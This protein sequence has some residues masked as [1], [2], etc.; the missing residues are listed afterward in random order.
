MLLRFGSKNTLD[1]A[2]FNTFSSRLETSS[3]N[4]HHCDAKLADDT[5]IFFFYKGE[6]NV[7][8]TIKPELEVFFDED[9]T[10]SF[11]GS[12]KKRHIECRNCNDIIGSV[13]SFG[14][15]S[16]DIKA[17]ACNRV[18]L[19]GKSYQGQRW[20][21]LYQTLPFESRDIQD[22]FKDPCQVNGM[23]TSPT[24]K[25]VVKEPV[26]FPSID[27]RKDFEWFTVS[28]TK[29][30]RD[31][32][33]QAFVEGLQKN[34]V[35]VLNT[36][37]GKTLIASM[38]LAKM[39]KLNP[40]RMGLMIVD[41][42]PL[43][44]Q[45]GDAIAEDTNLPVVSLCGENKTINII[46]K[47]N[48]GSY[49][50]LVVTAGA[51][52]EMLEKQSVDVSLFCAV[53]FDECHH[54]TGNHRYV[55]VM[56]KITSQILSHQPR[57]IGLTASPFTAST[58]KQGEINL[59]KFL[60]NFTD[61]K[62]YSP[63]LELSHQKTKKE[64]ISLSQDQQSFIKEVVARINEHIAEIVKA[65]DLQKFELKVDLS[66]TYQ[67]IGDLR[68]IE[69]HYPERKKNKDLRNALLL[70]EALEFAF[71]FGVPSACKFLKEEKV[72]DK[73]RKNFQYVT[74]L[75][76]RL[77][78]L[79]LYLKKANEGSRILVFVDRRSIARLLKRW[80]QKHFPDLNA[81]MVVGHGGYDGMAW[82]DQQQK[83]IR[84]FAKGESRLIVTTSVLEEGID[85]AQCDLVIAFTK[86]R[87]LIRFIQMRGRA[88]K[89]DSVFVIFE[90]EEERMSN[91][92]SENQEKVMRRVLAKHQ[93][94][95]FSVL[96][97]NIVEEIKNE[98]KS[99]E[100]AGDSST[101]VE[102]SLF[103]TSNN[104]L[105]FKLFMDPSEPINPTNMIEHI[106]IILKEIEFFKLKRFDVVSQ[107]GIFANSHVFS[108][109]ARM[110]IAY[111]SPISQSVT[112]SALYRRFVSFFDYRI[113]IADT[114]C[115][116]WS[117]TVVRESE[118]LTENQRVTSKKFSL[119]YFQNRSTVVVARTFEIESEIL[120]NCRKSIDIE[121]QA[122]D[123]EKIVINFSAMSK[124]I[125]L[126]VNKDDIVL[127]ITLS[128][129]PLFSIFDQG[130]GRWIRICGGEKP[131]YFSQHSLLML[132]FNIQD[133]LNLQK[134]F[135]SP[136]LFP[137]RILQTKLDLCN[138][139]SSSQIE[140]TIPWALKCIIDCREVCFP[141][142][143]LEKI[144]KELENKCN[145]QNPRGSRELC[146]SILSKLSQTNYRYF[147]DLNQQFIDTFNIAI[148]TPLVNKENKIVVKNVFH[149]KR[150]TVTP[151][152]IIS[153]PEILVASNRFLR[154]LQNQAEDVIIVTVRDDDTTKVQSDSFVDRFQKIF[155]NGIDICNKKYR[156]LLSTGSQIREHKGYFIRA[157]TLEEISAL[158]Q[159]FIPEPE[160][161]SSVAK[162]ICRL[163]MYGTTATYT[164]DLSM[165]SFI[166]ADDIK[167]ENGDLTTDGAGLISLSK[168]KELA[169]VLELDETPSAFQIR[170]SGFKGVVSCTYDDDPQLDGK[171][172]LMRKSMKKF[173]NGD[174]KF[175]VVQ[176]SKYRKLNLNREILNLLTSIK[177]YNIKNTLFRY[178]DKDL[179]E[180]VSM[181]ENDKIALKYLQS[182]L[183]QNDLKLI[184]NDI[185]KFTENKHWFEV[186]KGIYRLRTMNIKNRMNIIIE[187]GAL[188]MGVPDPYEVL[189]E[190]EVFVQLREEESSDPRIIQRR[191]FMYRNP[192]LHPG[193]HQIV[194]CVDSGKLHH[195]YNVVVIPAFH[196]KTSLAADCSGGDLDGDHFSVIWDENLV[197]PGNFEPLRYGELNKKDEQK[198]ER[199][200]EKENFQNPAAI[201]KFFTDFMINDELG[202]IAHKHLALCDIQDLGAR[203]ELAIEL[204]KC[205]VQAVHYSKT[206]IKP[207]MPK[208][209]IEIVS[210]SGFPDF[211]EKKFEESYQSV[212]NLGELYRHCKE[213]TF[214]FDPDLK[215]HRNFSD[216]LEF[217]KVRGFQKYIEDAE[218]VYE[219]YKYHVQMIIVK[220][221]LKTEV[222]V[223][224]AS[225]TYGWADE[226]EGNKEK[227]SEIIK[228][229]YAD[230]KK[231]CRNLFLNDKL[232]LADE[233]E[234]S[235]K[236]YAWYYVAYSKKP[237]DD[238]IKFLGFPWIVA[239]YL[240]QIRK[241]KDQNTSNKIN[242][243]IG[244]SVV[245]QF[246]QKY[247]KTLIKD[248]QAKFNYVQR[249]E[250]AINN[251]TKDKYQISRGFIVQPYG[252]TSLYVCEP[253]SDIDIC[254]V[255]T[256]ELS[257]T[258]VM[259]N[260]YFKILPEHKQQEYFL[261]LVVSRV[262]DSLACEKRD[263]FN[264]QTPFV[265][266]KSSNE[267]D[268]FSCDI[269]MNVN[270]LKKTYYFHHL[271]KKD[272][273]YF[274]VF[275]SLVKWARAA[276]LIRPFA[277]AEKG[278]IDTADFYALIAHTLNFPE[279]PPVDIT[280]PVNTINLS[281]L[282]NIILKCN[283][284]QKF[285]GI[286]PRVGEMI[287]LFFKEVSMKN[288]S[289]TIEWS[290]VHG[291]ED[292]K[293]VI[294]KPLVMSSISS[295]ASKAFHCLSVLRDSEG[296]LN[297]FMTSDECTEFTKNLST[298]LSFAIGKAKE[299]HSALL[300]ANTGAIVRIDTIDGL[301][302]YR[303]VAKGTRLQLDKLKKEIR[304]L[305]ESNRA[306]VLGR[307]PQ[308][309]SRYFMEGSS[310]LFSLQDTD[311]DSRVRFEPS[312]GA[313]QV[314]HRLRERESLILQD[315]DKE[316]KEGHEKEQYD[317][318]KAHIIE[319]MSS[320]PAKN[321][322]LLES[323]Q[324][325][326]RFGC[327]YFIEV[328]SNLPS[329]SKTVLFQELQI[330]LDKGR[331]K[332]SFWDREFV[333]REE[334]ES[335]TAAKGRS[336]Q[337]TE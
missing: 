276:E 110:F 72:L 22:F 289:I 244:K 134:I 128:Q 5:Q 100:R 183:P 133:Y 284:K 153:L 79:D 63:R 141:P 51:F 245:L 60:E 222:D 235:R 3:M 309:T 164:F 165:D 225:A 174:R 31:Y 223:I 151:T 311:Y 204:A 36:G 213:T 215:Q 300:G 306:L 21:N 336:Q 201:A 177:D 304:S 200:K 106:R 105:A 17:F 214:L 59:E 16:R 271:F 71:Y 138:S 129:V 23:A 238:K 208:K 315:V 299:F 179:E 234:K 62:I 180:L 269:S 66:N 34:I 291:L 281:T 287:L 27:K 41:R 302:N 142:D 266:F 247:Y 218:S 61:A 328:S 122:T 221:K 197:P 326:V 209:A 160:K 127:Y 229:W 1:F 205:Q 25:K 320:F 219:F 325:F 74:E 48:R 207:I 275:W 232:L 104:E 161:F 93:R 125:F 68:S 30:P 327:M 242:Y 2:G 85:V 297:Y 120:F 185:S 228:T 226:I 230:I 188:L 285:K 310:K 259:T 294:I 114:V 101:C 292:V 211:M 323:I 176:Y 35:V 11:S 305:M 8:L 307:L 54:L 216:Y 52:Y 6:R 231:T 81:Q 296:L 115:Q 12:G 70:I 186:L 168:A 146:E 92:K 40:G 169:G 32:Q 20:Y 107:K 64:L 91:R 108:S 53:I 172:F 264:S 46:N 196:C 318:F 149:I 265:K 278:V 126:T 111:V 198:N 10:L 243:I 261:D 136:S 49:D 178:M 236:A 268:R 154:E 314:L 98:C 272:W 263:I 56:K 113:T 190:N 249:V 329:E 288:E 187:D 193:D 253:E 312:Q 286:F 97:K 44:F 220:Y 337:K 158:R 321:T 75:S 241:R 206:G 224:L 13:L 194:Q 140:R 88:R 239:D 132:T 248:I 96:S 69:R 50:V 42:V 324:V 152:R 233:K 159:R 135:H 274:I 173:E 123:L 150:V 7:H 184:Y 58:E 119:G 295:Q 258:I 24:K 262:V 212:K 166:L 37:A 333:G 90:T 255:A 65:Y 94:C 332:R 118:D 15:G 280:E 29:S 148:D 316:W 254:A 330:A 227:I 76:G 124:F 18:K 192:C 82:E 240:C 83:C 4:C 102:L 38:I 28:L 131:Y 130:E 290:K 195:L 277:E 246:K 303:V 334:N 73:V 77:Q 43:V 191:A 155:L 103:K 109:N 86:L 308:T 217:V 199:K 121:L 112:P 167:A 202:K 279:A 182:Y 331:R 298:S 171:S 267:E 257:D 84:E 237:A 9:K 33:I 39:C 317:R 87:S 143:T 45:Q 145:S 55:D 163:G 335:N 251:F 293:D 67:I 156:Y 301:K 181:F 80:I 95:N 144:L 319:Q 313:C 19:C 116:L 252:S 139:F 282:Y 14:P 47:I 157:D 260:K 203:D 162:F 78:K 270:G 147:V 250:R 273:T 256:A 117:N 89:V 26:N 175:C 137:F 210:N 283:K 99:I 322:D 170:Y 189:K 57:I